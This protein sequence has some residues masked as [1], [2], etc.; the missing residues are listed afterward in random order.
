M[1]TSIFLTLL[2]DTLKMAGVALFGMA[3]LQDIM[4]RLVPNLVPLSIVGVSLILRTLDGN[5]APSL[6]AG[7]VVFLLAAACWRRGWLGGADVKLFGAG[8]LLVPSNA[9]FGF[10]LASCLAGGVSRPASWAFAAVIFGR[11]LT[12]CKHLRG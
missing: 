11:A 5:L 10:V 8:A 7:A 12:G 1:E 4:L 2:S 9:A 3:M 6:V